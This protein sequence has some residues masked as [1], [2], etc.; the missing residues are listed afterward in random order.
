MPDVDPEVV[1]AEVLPEVDALVDPVVVPEVVAV[2]E[3]VVEVVDPPE[4]PEPS[5]EVVSSLQPTT[6]SAVAEETRKMSVFMGWRLS[7]PSVPGG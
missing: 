6:A 5:V 1:E 4:P 2:V 7:T 3:V